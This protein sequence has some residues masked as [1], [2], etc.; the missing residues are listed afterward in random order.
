MS[1]LK[2]DQPQAGGDGAPAGQVAVRARESQVL[3]DDDRLPEAHDRALC[4]TASRVDELAAAQADL[5]M[6]LGGDGTL[7]SVARST[8]T[9]HVPILGV[10]LGTLGF[11]TEINVDEMV[12]ALEKVVAGDFE[13]ESRMRLEVVVLRGGEELARY[14]ALNDAVHRQDRALAHDRPGT[15]RTA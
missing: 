13:I 9:R 1:V 15:T 6:V 5:I 14:Q 4:A 8:G 7:L 12:P 11:L 2:P 3:L 10:N